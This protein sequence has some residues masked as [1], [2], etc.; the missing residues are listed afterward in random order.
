MTQTERR[1]FLI[2]ELL[3]EQPR[4]GGLEIPA[5]GEGQRRML[6]SLINLRPPW[7]AAREFLQVQDA[8]LR[9]ATRRKEITTLASLRPVQKGLYLWQGDIT[10]L[11]CGAIVNAANSQLLGCFVPCH[12]CIDNSIP[13]QITHRF[14]TLR[15]ASAYRRGAGEAASITGLVGT[16]SAFL[17]KRPRAEKRSRSIPGPGAL[18]DRGSDLPPQTVFSGESFAPGLSRGGSAVG[19]CKGDIP[20]VGGYRKGSFPTVFPFRQIAAAFFYLCSDREII[21]APCDRTGN[22]PVFRI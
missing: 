9:E 17:G 2:R 22:I 16:A 8:Y 1:I 19:K 7:P 5:D 6:R 20:V 12:G 14:I 15:R 3:R 18:L 4:Y 13:V 11:A 21:V 10:T